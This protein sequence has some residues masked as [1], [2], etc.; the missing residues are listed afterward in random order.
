MEQTENKSVK[1]STKAL[2]EC[3]EAQSGLTYVDGC[4][5]KRTECRRKDHGE[6]ERAI[7]EK[8]VAT[9]DFF[10]LR[11]VA[12]LSFATIEMVTNYIAFEKNHCDDPQVVFPVAEYDVIK[13]SL[14]RLVSNALVNKYEYCVP[15][16]ERTYVLY[17]A[18]DAGCQCL[19]RILYFKEPFESLMAINDI[20][21]VLK[22]IGAAFVGLRLAGANAVTNFQGFSETG[23]F[24]SVGKFPF[25][26]RVFSEVSGRKYVTLV[27]PFYF[28]FNPRVIEKETRNR[29]V[30][31]RLDVIREYKTVLES[32][33]KALRV[34]VVVED[35]KGLIEAVKL[36][37][38]SS[39]LRDELISMF[40]FTSRQ[41]ICEKKDDLVGSV[42]RIEEFDQTGAPKVRMCSN[43][44]FIS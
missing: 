9:S 19:R 15:K 27:E 2:L 39:F 22:R 28:N 6:I 18:T 1:D 14:G 24:K 38:A 26:G 40:Y 12:R 25:Y 41:A 20:T 10:V 32:D 31:S 4:E 5:L 35:K 7:F 3:M 43:L 23:Y 11:A 37:Q 16:S 17:V 21:E 13:K 30:L 8:A 33:D 34:V 42:L 36:L 29:I 44:D